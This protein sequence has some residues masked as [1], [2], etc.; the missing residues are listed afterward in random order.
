MEIQRKSEK[1]NCRLYTA[2]GWP[3][4]QGSRLLSPRL[5]LI[6]N[7]SVAELRFEAAPISA[8]TIFPEDIITRDKMLLHFTL[9]SVHRLTSDVTY[10]TPEI[11]SPR[12]SEDI[13][14]SLAMLLKDQIKRRGRSPFKPY[15][16]SPDGPLACARILSNRIRGRV[17]T[18]Q[19]RNRTCAISNSDSKSSVSDR[20]A[21]GTPNF[22]VYR[23]AVCRK[24]RRKIWC[25]R[26]VII[27]R[28]RGKGK[29]RP[30]AMTLVPWCVLILLDEDRSTAV[31]TRTAVPCLERF[32]TPLIYQLTA[33][34]I[35]RGTNIKDN[36]VT[37][38][39]TGHTAQH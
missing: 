10:L 13:K 16:V 24:L 4:L 9:C 19:D 34:R 39:L 15:S 21:I 1:L 32:G 38:P 18:V 31:A 12:L 11:W 25:G 5:L 3:T 22:H 28:E 17:D 26:K 2:S 33:E 6:V 30:Y 37:P 29:L 27:R 7:Q 35:R 36:D 8:T 23:Y 20:S 14:K